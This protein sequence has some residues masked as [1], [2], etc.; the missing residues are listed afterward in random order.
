M[1]AERSP[2]SSDSQTQR[3]GQLIVGVDGSE[4]GA[5]ALRQAVKEAALHGWEVVA[6]MAWNYLDQ[7]HLGP[8]PR[9]DPEF[10]DDQALEVLA[11]AVEQAIGPE[12]AAQVR[13]QVVTDLPARALLE[14]AD[15]AE[16]LVVGARG[17]GGFRT[18]LLGSVSD[19]CLQHAPVPVMV[20]RPLT[21]P[22]AEPE[23]P[24]EHIVVGIDESP[25]SRLALRWAVD[26]ARVR[27]ATL[28][29]VRSWHV[30]ALG[31]GD[32]VYPLDPAA[33][34]EESLRTIDRALAEVD[35]SGLQ[36]PPNRLTAPGPATNAILHAANDATLVVVGTRGTGGFKGLLLGSVSH[37]VARHADC[38]VVVVPLPSR[39]R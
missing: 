38:P 25:A 23:P 1:D 39:H 30:P 13:L 11:K 15:D 5:A 31:V 36:A 6:F 2:R 16:L 9:F 27:D 8:E 29:V 12:A 28:S 37:Q 24:D 4:G 35:V 19:Q 26:E 33:V 22:P 10:D 34:E 21:R 18:L 14:R 3:S 20:V 17:L 32:I 7:P